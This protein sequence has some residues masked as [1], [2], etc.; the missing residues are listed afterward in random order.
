[1]MERQQ[2]G[3]KIAKTE[4]KNEIKM[5]YPVL[6]LNITEIVVHRSE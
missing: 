3:T 1:M 4:I 5:N 6:R 2:R